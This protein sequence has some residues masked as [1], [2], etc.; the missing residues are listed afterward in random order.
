MT[1]HDTDSRIPSTRFSGKSIADST[2][3]SVSGCN[4]AGVRKADINS[5]SNNSGDIQCTIERSSLKIGAM[6]N[7]TIVTED[8]SSAQ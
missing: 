1:E 5:G 8:L 6:H 7:R 4:S 2:G 3:G